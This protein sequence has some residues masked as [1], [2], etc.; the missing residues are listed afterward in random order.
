MK[1]VKKMWVENRVLFVL[2]VI[3][4]I[5]LF[6]ILG[7]VLKYFFGASSSSYGDRLDGINEVEVTDEIKNN[8]LSSMKEDALIEDATIKTRGKIIYITLSFKDGVTLEEA[9]SKAL[10]S[11][12][13]FEQQYLDFY[14]FNY[15]LKGNAT[16]NSEGFLI[17]GA[18]NVNGSGLVWNNNT[19]V[20]KNEE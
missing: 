13:A 9:K 15:T 18:R 7:V 17:M 14:D 5:C 8:F 1:K 3:V 11:L 10:A 16:E 2:F 12:M 4:L 19:E 6:I 20:V